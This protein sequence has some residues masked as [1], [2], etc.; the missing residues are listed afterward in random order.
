MTE[1]E[2]KFLIDFKSNNICFTPTEFELLKN[3]L[4]EKDL[5]KAID[6]LE[7]AARKIK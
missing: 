4:K 2:R 6:I 3:K 5:S 7:E 1:K